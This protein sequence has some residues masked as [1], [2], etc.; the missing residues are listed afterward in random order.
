MMRRKRRS[1]MLKQELGQSVDHLKR[2]AALAAQETGATVG[3]RIYAARDRVQPAAVKAKDAASSGW[4]SAVATLTPLVV[5]A[6]DNV[7]A[8]S[9][10]VRAA[11]DS[12]RQAG[13]KSVEVSRKTAKANKKSAKQSAKKLEKRANKTLGRQQS[14]HRGSR[15]LGFALVGTAVGAGAAYVLR[16]RRAAQWDEYD[17]SRPI[18]TP[19]PAEGADDAAFEPTDPTAYSTPAGPIS[20]SDPAV[21]TEPSDE[22]TAPQ[23]PEVARIASG[24]TTKKD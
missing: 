10:S 18:T 3:P 12:V 7:R 16:R 13:Q 11:S 23:S 4:E 9:D 1:A 22:A 19:P 21:I 6:S 14:S 2:A 24:N 20:D 17:P 5:A 8:A 15:L